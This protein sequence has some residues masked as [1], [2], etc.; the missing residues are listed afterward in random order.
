MSIAPSPPPDF[1]SLYE[2][3]EGLFSRDVDGHL[4][5]MDR[6]TAEDFEK[7]ITLKIDGKDVTVKKAVPATDS[8]GNILRDENGAIV[9]DAIDTG[10]RD[11]VPETDWKRPPGLDPQRDGDPPPSL[12][13]LRGGRG[14]VR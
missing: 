3:E 9:V 5:R 4:V 1:E 6:V 11:R 8:V 10:Y 12:P 2:E 14:Q 13:P 7:D